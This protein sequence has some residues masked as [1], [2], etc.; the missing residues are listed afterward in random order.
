MSKTAACNAFNSELGLF[1]WAR[2]VESKTEEVSIY[3]ADGQAIAQLKVKSIATSS[4]LASLASLRLPLS[5]GWP[6]P[7]GKMT[8][9]C[10]TTCHFLLFDFASV[11]GEHLFA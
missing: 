4:E 9:S 6:P 1:E 5:L 10:N 2:L 3:T 11:N 8:V 7:S